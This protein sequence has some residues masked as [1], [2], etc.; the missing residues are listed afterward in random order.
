MSPR[1][2]QGGRGRSP[3]GLGAGGRL[4]LAVTAEAVLKTVAPGNRQ[5][6]LEGVPGAAK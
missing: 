3:V 5:V 6:L 2:V 4:V 1:P